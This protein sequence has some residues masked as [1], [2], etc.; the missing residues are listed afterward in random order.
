M[1]FSKINARNGILYLLFDIIFFDHLKN[2]LF[3]FLCHSA[4][5]SVNPYSP[6]FSSVNTYPTPLTVLMKEYLP[7]STFVRKRPI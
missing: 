5:L 1:L 4:L 3:I 7:V 2:V 6:G